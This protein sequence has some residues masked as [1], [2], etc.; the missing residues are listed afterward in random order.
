MCVNKDHSFN[1]LISN[2]LDITHLKFKCTDLDSLQLND[3][4]GKPYVLK[5][6][7]KKFDA[8]FDVTVHEPSGKITASVMSLIKNFDVRY[9]QLVLLVSN[10]FI[11]LFAQCMV[12]LSVQINC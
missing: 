10:T 3:K 6:K 4:E 9:K 7:L 5:F 12:E 8:P 11:S 1:L 2:I